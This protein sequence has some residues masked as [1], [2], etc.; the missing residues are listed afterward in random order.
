[1]WR[2]TR[3]DLPKQ[4]KQEVMAPKICADGDKRLPLLSKTGPHIITGYGV[5]SKYKQETRSGHV[6]PHLNSTVYFYYSVFIHYS[7]V[8]LVH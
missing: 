4:A 3:D 7:V 5:F 2:G 6:G 8:Y 1:M